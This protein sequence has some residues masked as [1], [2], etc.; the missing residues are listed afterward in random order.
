M[1]RLDRGS[2]RQ[3]RKEPLDIEA[4]QVRRQAIGGEPDEIAPDGIVE[5]HPLDPAEP[6]ENGPRDQ[7][8]SIARHEAGLAFGRQPATLFRLERPGVIDCR[9]GFPPVELDGPGRTDGTAELLQVDRKRTTL[10]SSY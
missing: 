8:R 5:G 6:V 2:G 1:A 4:R 3:A 10:N 7:R 9:G